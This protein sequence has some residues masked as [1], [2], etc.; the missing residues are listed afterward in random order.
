MTKVTPA[1]IATAALGLGTIG[2]AAAAMRTQSQLFGPTLVAGH[3]PA[4][5][6]LTFDDGPNPWATPRLLDLLARAGVRAT[7]FMIG[8]FARL[9][10]TLVRDVAREGHLVGNHTMSHPRLSL[11]SSKQIQAQLVHCN[12]TLE[13]L[14]GS[15]IHLLRPPHGAVRPAVLRIARELG[16]TTTQW[17]VTTFDW[18]A[19][20]A[21]AVY[22][23]LEQGVRRNQRRGRS[24]NIL[25]HDGIDRNPHARQQATVAATKQLLSIHRDTSERYVTPDLWTR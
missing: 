10:P 6:A 4:E 19:I 5:I 3:N 14:L 16:L 22:S 17:N 8:N 15:P 7:F 1:R 21:E 11:L 23:K 20:P 13:D 2:F 12:Q 18:T 24:S 9:Q 25:L